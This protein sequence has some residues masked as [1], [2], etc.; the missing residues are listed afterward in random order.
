VNKGSTRPDD[1]GQHQQQADAHEHGHEQT[2]AA[3]E[4]APLG[5]QLVHQDRDEDDVVDAQHQLERGERGKGDP[6]LGVGQQF[7]RGGG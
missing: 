6:G 4:F 1:P 7:H 5:W 2:Q 3:R